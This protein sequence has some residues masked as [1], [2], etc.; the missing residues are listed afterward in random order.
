MLCFPYHKLNNILKFHQNPNG[1]TPSNLIMTVTNFAV[2][3]KNGANGTVLY[4][5]LAP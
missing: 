2:T 4:F 5:I 3:V 1:A